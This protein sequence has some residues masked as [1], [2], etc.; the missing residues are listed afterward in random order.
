MNK[1]KVVAG[2][3][4]AGML[5]SAC[6]TTKSTS[7]TSG[8]TPPVAS[9]AGTS[10]AADAA[11][12]SLAKYQKMVDTFT[13]AA[14]WN[15][16][17]TS[18]KAPAG[19]SAGILSCTYALE[20][21]RLPTQGIQAALKKLHWTQKTV[22]STDPSQY[23]AAM[24]SLLTNK[25]DVI[26]L[27]G[28]DQNIVKDAIAA[29]H[30]SHILV[31]SVV[32]YNTPG[33]DGV[34]VEVSPDGTK[35]GQVL[36]AQMIVD[37]QGKVDALDMHDG[38]FGLA[39]AVENGAMDTLKACATCKISTTVNF[40]ASELQSSMPTKAVT[41]L[42]STPSIN[43]IFI[44]YDPT[45]T[46]L[47]PAVINA[48]LATKVR[49]YSQLGTTDALNYL[50]Q[51]KV[52]AADIATPEAWAGWGAVDEA[53]RLLNKQPTVNENLP[54]KVLTKSNL[55]APGQPFTGDGVDYQGEY[56]KLWGVSG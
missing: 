48:G 30:A 42:Q 44:G 55:P 1:S 15:G 51:G 46:F 25:P 23:S 29:A 9:T 26:F 10:S 12:A 31:V 52:L 47:A 43:T 13:A 8:T 4:A 54:I 5:M 14:K 16:P 49:L 7:A 39:V 35:M 11:A 50:R 21:C 22:V 28:I 27:T 33:P 41:A 20:G 17:T 6:A 56:L 34:D 19:K 32:Q 24:K 40:T 3:L 53:I 18:T 36:A 45:V 38:E 37:A 2:L